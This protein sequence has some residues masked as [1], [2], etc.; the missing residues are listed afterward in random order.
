MNLKGPEVESLLHEGSFKAVCE[1][2]G[3]ASADPE[4]MDTP[5]SLFDL[6]ETALGKQPSAS[7]LISEDNTVAVHDTPRVWG[8]PF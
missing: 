8:K 6:V 1:R 4:R 3:K 7:H 2:C 5:S